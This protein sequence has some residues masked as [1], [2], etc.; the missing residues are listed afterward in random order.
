M[1]QVSSCVGLL[2][3]EPMGAVQFYERAFGMRWVG[4]EHGIELS[5]GP[6]RLFVDPGEPR[7]LVLELLTPDLEVARR[8]VAAFGF[9]RLLWEGVGRTNLVR[10]PFGLLWN[11]FEDP[12]AFGPPDLEPPEVGVAKACVGG[13]V[14]DPGH[15]ASFYARVLESAPN[16]LTDNS[17]AV[18]SGGMRARFRYSERVSPAIW[19]T[20]APADGLRREGVAE[21]DPGVFVDPFGVAWCVELGEKPTHAAVTPL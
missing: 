17:W 5:A 15:V 9:E 20:E 8:R 1:F 2:A 6:L 14:P 3:R 21:S 7:P 4:S 10:D 11:V 13:L 19:L 18:D 12:H 16:R